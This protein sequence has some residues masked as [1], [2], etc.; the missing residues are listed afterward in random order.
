MRIVAIL[1]SHN[2]REKTLACLQSYFDQ[3]LRSPATLD[4]V[5]V[6]DGSNDGT[7][8]VVQVM[9][10]PVTVVC[11]A[12]DLYWAGG[13][14]LAEKD[15]LRRAPDYLL[16]LNDDVILDRDAVARLL[17]VAKTNDSK[18]IVVGAVRDPITGV[19]TYSGLCRQDYHPLRF[20]C[21]EPVDRSQTVETFNGN[22]V[23]VPIAVAVSIG[24]ID[25]EFAHG[26]ADYDYGLRATKAGVIN[27]L[28]PGTVGMCSS[29]SPYKPWLNPSAPF[30]ERL[31][32]L[33]GPKGLPPRSF[34]RYL[35]RHGGRAWVIFWLALYV[36]FAMVSLREAVARSLR[37]RGPISKE[38]G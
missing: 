20:E 12:G 32:F 1:T 28:A 19:V 7:A 18:C 17:D 30:R 33:L 10:A 16:W 13:M 22:V 15:A 24:G 5:L 26:A 21:I 27:L 8:E 35:H 4:A 9:G 31:R 3:A 11:G 37:L 6:D 36:K 34:A 25:G 29:D 2:R 23:L 38:G 14:A